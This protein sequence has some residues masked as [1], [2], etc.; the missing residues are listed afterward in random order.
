M[1]VVGFRAVVAPFDRVVLVVIE[2]SVGLTGSEMWANFC[3]PPHP[4][5]PPE[6]RYSLSSSSAIVIEADRIIRVVIADAITTINSIID[7]PRNQQGR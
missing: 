7:P 5:P 2:I 4:P 1:P 3:A 6:D